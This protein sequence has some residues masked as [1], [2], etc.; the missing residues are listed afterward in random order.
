MTLGI[1]ITVVYAE[2][3]NLALYAL[4]IVRFRK[5]ETIFS[6]SYHQVHFLPDT[7]SLNE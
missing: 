7:A 3:H 2:L 6:L 5:V 4:Q 1:I